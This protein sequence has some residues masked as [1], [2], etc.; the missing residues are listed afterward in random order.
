M[1]PPC[2]DELLVLGVT[3]GHI[4]ALFLFGY[5]VIVRFFA[6]NI[7]NLIRQLIGMIG[8]FVVAEN[9]TQWVKE[10]GGWVSH[11]IHTVSDIW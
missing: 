5:R 7:P 8:R 6:K 9:I 11:C 4:V 3:W 2:I 10:H 1:T